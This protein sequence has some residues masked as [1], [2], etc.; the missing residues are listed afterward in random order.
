MCAFAGLCFGVQA[1]LVKIAYQNGLNLDTLLTMRFVVAGTSIW[2]LVALVRPD[3]RLPAPRLVG[4]GLL[5]AIFVTSSLFYYL[6]LSEMAAG[7][8]SLLVF[9]YPAI[10]VVL[11]VLFLGEKLGA[12][13][14]IALVLA[15]V[16]CALT[17]DPV[18]ALAPG[19]AFS[20]LGVLFATGSAFSNAVY[21]T[22]SG[23]FG[24]GI[25]GLVSAAYSITVTALLFVGW[26]WLSDSF[27]FG[28][29]AVGWAC[30][31]GVG[32]L[33]A[34]GIVTFLAGLQIV[35]A[36]RAAIT[37]TTE[38]AISVLLGIWLLGEPFSLLKIVG[39]IL[40]IGAILVLSRPVK[41]NE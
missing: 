38:P 32:L 33:T 30:C 11:A 27:F 7:T 28:M 24:R 6:A 34:I 5:G 3:L 9:S 21:S 26:C 35:G 41:Q 31:I 19:Q 12:M 25:P 8:A 20:W 4:L 15:L 39:G 22:L 14:L 13:R 2:L 40:I 17:V 29:S 37:S 23:K 36:S 10:V 1:P 16:G 18:V